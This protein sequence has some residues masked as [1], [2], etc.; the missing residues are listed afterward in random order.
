MVSI[1]E[2]CACP[3]CH[4]EV[5]HQDPGTVQKKGTHLYYCSQSCASGHALQAGCGHE[6]CDCY[7]S[8]DEVP[9]K[10]SVNAFGIKEL[11]EP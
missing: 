5:D 10:E 3:R 2:S 8:P 11:E 7:S 4:C 9:H 1:V 6:G